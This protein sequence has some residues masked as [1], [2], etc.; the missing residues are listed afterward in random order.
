MG[1]D[2]NHQS[3]D[4]IEEFETRLRQAQGNRREEQKKTDNS[5]GR[6]IGFAFR[7]ATD[8][9]CAIAVGVGVGWGLDHWLDTKPIF[10]ILFFFLGVAAGVLNVIRAANKAT[11]LASSDDAKKLPTIDDGDD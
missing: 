4:R 7:I 5:K 10:L 2:K 3:S 11:I 6:A 9:V 1:G 8:L